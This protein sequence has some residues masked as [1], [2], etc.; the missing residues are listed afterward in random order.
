MAKSVNERARDYQRRKAAEFKLLPPEE[1]E[2]IRAKK[3]AYSL[4]YYYRNREER[5]AASVAANKARH[6]ARATKE[7]RPF[8][9]LGIEHGNS[10]EEKAARLDVRRQKKRAYDAARYEQVAEQKKTSANAWYA[11]NRERGLAKSNARYQVKRD[12]ILADKAAKRRAAIAAD[13]SYR[14]REAAQN[15]K[16]YAANPAKYRAI[17]TAAHRRYME[18]HPGSLAERMRRRYWSDPE[19]ARERGI[20]DAAA[21]RA[22]KLNSGGEFTA[23]D[24]RD[25]LEKQKGKCLVCLTPFGNA[26][27]HV[28]HYVSLARGGTNNPSNL[29]LLC[30]KCNM[31]KH[32]KDPIAFGR[33]KGLLVW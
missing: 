14:E 22:R 32:A 24:V 3:S 23:A 17:H 31:S 30:R 33:E 21:R 20:V 4:A 1:Q 6:Q 11:A 18:R 7:G 10:P 2:A 16:Q 26:K 19:G 15:R 25:L 5:I 9:R 28:D 12:E 27:P 13:P 29:R 8:G